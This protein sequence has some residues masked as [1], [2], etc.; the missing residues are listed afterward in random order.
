MPSTYIDDFIN[1]DVSLLPPV[2]VSSGIG[3][4]VYCAIEST[5]PIANNLTSVNGPTAVA[6]LLTATQISAQAAA[7]LTVMFSQSP[8]PSR[9]W[10]AVY[11]PPALPSAALDVAVAADTPFG[12]I[13]MESRV[14]ADVE[15]VGAWMAARP[16]I[17]MWSPQTSEA[18]MLTAGKPADLEGAEISWSCMNW[19]SLDTESQG[20]AFGAFMAAFPLV[21]RPMGMKVR[22]LGVALPTITDAQ[23]AFAKEND[24]MV[25]RPVGAGASASQRIIDQT[26]T[27]SAENFTAV[28]TLVY[29]VR[30]CVA[31]IQAMSLRYA[32]QGKPLFATSAGAA[33]LYQVLNSPLSSL[34]KAGHFVPGMSGTPPDE[35]ALPAGYSLSVAPSGNLLIATVLVRLGQ[36]VVGI[37]LNVTGEV[38]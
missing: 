16:W 19:H 21:S 31:A 33:D 3:D 13:T 26:L 24:A 38:V 23:L 8:R 9:I 10:I 4:A 30:R 12:V 34:A 11:D 27:Y 32:I 7:D 28:I 1:V 14:D 6:D 18:A 17:Y 22:L 5:V 15:D 29:L 35:V 2:V 20:P 25:L 36:E 37:N